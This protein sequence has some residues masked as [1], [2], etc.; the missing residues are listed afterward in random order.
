MKIIKF[1]FIFSLI[2][3]TFTTL[4]DNGYI[5]HNLWVATGILALGV[6]FFLGAWLIG[7]IISLIFRL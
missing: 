3:G 5:P 6:L 7:E 4:F 1:L 2:F